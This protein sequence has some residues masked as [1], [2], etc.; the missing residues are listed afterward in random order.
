[1]MPALPTPRSTDFVTELERLLGEG[2]ADHERR[3]DATGV[4]GNDQHR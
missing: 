2:D 4:R 1:M 3:T